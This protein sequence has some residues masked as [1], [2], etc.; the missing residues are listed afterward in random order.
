[1]F[2][3][4]FNV[5]FDLRATIQGL[6]IQKMPFG[7]ELDKQLEILKEIDEVNYFTKLNKFNNY[8]LKQLI[9]IPILQFVMKMRFR[10]KS[11]DSA[12]LP[13]QE[14]VV[15]NCRALPQLHAELQQRFP[16]EEILLMTYRIGQDVLEI[17]FSVVRA[18]G[19]A[20]TCPTSL[21]TIYRLTKHA[22]M[23]TPESCLQGNSNVMVDPDFETLSGK[24]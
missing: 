14:G 19:V 4:M 9:F 15:Q 23:K 17:L 16:D 20:N 11:K 8:R 1:M 18:A 2:I 13:F 3:D 7:A 12:P 10:N 22:L 5:R 6:K 21:E 24:V